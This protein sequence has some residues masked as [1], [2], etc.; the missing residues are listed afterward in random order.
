MLARAVDAAHRLRLLHRGAAARP[1]PLSARTDSRWLRSSGVDQRSTVTCTSRRRGAVRAS[2]VDRKGAELLLA[3]GRRGARGRRGGQS[4]EDHGGDDS[5]HECSPAA[6]KGPPRD[7]TSRPPA[8]CEAVLYGEWKG[9]NHAPIPLFDR[10]RRALA[11][12]SPPPPRWPTAR[13]PRDVGGLVQPRAAD[14]GRHRRPRSPAPS[15]AGSTP[16][17]PRCGAMRRCCSRAASKACSRTTCRRRD[18]IP[19]RTSSPRRTRRASRYTRGRT[20]G[21]STPGIPRSSPRPGR[22]WCRAIP[23]TCS[24][25]M[26]GASRTTNTG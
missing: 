8:G 3:F 5:L 2:E 10:R 19:S 26:D 14:A 9:E 25:C 7:R 21:P 16:S 11:S 18:S 13:G 12:H 24:T 6:Q 1:G 22:A 4:G 15:G 20:S 17:S 23:T